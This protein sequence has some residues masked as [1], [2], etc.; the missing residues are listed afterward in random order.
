MATA[1]SLSWRIAFSVGDVNTYAWRKP[2]SQEF[3]TFTTSH[4]SISLLSHP[5]D[6]TVYLVI[7][8]TDK[9]LVLNFGE[10]YRTFTYWRWG[11]TIVTY[12]HPR[13]EKG[14]ILFFPTAAA[15]ERFEECSDRNLFPTA[16]PLIPPPSLQDLVDLGIISVPKIIGDFMDDAAAVEAVRGSALTRHLEGAVDGLSGLDGATTEDVV[17]S[18][19]EHAS[20]SND[21]ASDV[22]DD[23]AGGVSDDAGS[24]SDGGESD[25]SHDGASELFDDGASELFDDGASDGASNVPDEADSDVS[26]LDSEMYDDM[27]DVLID[28][29]DGLR[30]DDAFDM[31]LETFD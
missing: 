4:A 3:T 14:L 11:T 7:K 13:G 24:D 25:I 21:S 6:L 5:R 20:N 18:D 26:S 30:A 9:V 10:L 28:L 27:A 16:R 22:S 17:D 8:G 2:T 31:S 1:P 29:F 19:L 23:G 15:L 12:R